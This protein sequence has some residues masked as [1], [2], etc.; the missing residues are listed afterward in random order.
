M[1]KEYIEIEREK[2]IE[3]FRSHLYMIAIEDSDKYKNDESFNRAIGEIC[4]DALDK[5]LESHPEAHNKVYTGR[6]WA[7]YIVDNLPLH[8]DTREVY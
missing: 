8:T 3:I 7:E 6:H 2:F 5:W 4:C 1:K